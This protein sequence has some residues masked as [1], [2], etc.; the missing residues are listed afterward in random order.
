MENCCI[1]PC[2]VGMLIPNELPF[3]ADR[4]PSLLSSLCVCVRACVRTTALVLCA[5]GDLYL[6]L[7][8]RMNTNTSVEGQRER[9]FLHSID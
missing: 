2:T 6:L 5:H 1:S 4:Y 8:S 9:G 7:G 3:R